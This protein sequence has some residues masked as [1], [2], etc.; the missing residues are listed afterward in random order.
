MNKRI[1]TLAI[2]AIFSVSIVMGVTTAQQ[3]EINIAFSINL[4]SP[5]T[6][7]ARN[8]WSLLMEQ[9]LPKIGIGITFHESTGWGNIAPRTWSYPFL[10]YDYIPTY[11][12]GGYDL[13]FVGWS[14]PLDL[15][16]QALYETTAITPNG[17]NHYQYSNP[18]YDTLL[19][20]Y[21]AELDTTQ[22]L[23]LAKDLQE[24]IYEDLPGIAL[25]YPRSLF[26]FKEGL[27]GIDDL[28]LAST[29]HRAE[30]WDDPDDHIIKYA[31]PADLREPNVYQAESFYD[32]QWMY[33]VYGCPLKRAQ[34]S[35]IW[36]PEIASAIEVST[37][38][39]DKINVTV[40]LDSLAKFSDDSD[41]LPEDL[42]Y[43]YEL[44]MT[45]A[46]GS[47][48]YG[49]LTYWFPT[50]SSIS[51]VGGSGGNV[52]GGQV[53]FEFSGVFNL[54]ESIFNTQIID[55]SEVQ[56][57]ISA[58]G[59]GIFNDVPGTGN[60]QWSLVKSCG[61]F[62]VESYDSINSVVKLVPNPYWHGE[63]VKL[64]EWYLTFI[65]GKDAAVAAL[66][67]DEIDLMDAQYFPVLA[68]FENQAGIEGVLV[69]D[70]SHQEMSI[71]M[72][73]PVMGTGELTPVGTAEAAKYVRKAISH[74]VPRQTI[75]DEILEGLG[76]PATTAVPDSVVGYDDTLEPYAYDL[77]LAIDYM[78]NAGFTVEVPYTSPTGIAGLIF[79][80]FL[81]LA[82]IE[83]MRRLRSK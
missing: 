35:H 1:M 2:I 48:N 21:M 31:I 25:V 32:W 54:W 39:D 72:L 22:R 17:D 57:L 37:V 24:I 7:P 36:E 30:F 19:E 28:L 4:L 53:L 45:P 44:H 18:A 50:N 20:D 68:D 46:V 13:L 43:S 61:P 73:H 3:T 55:K 67:A 47:S 79:I 9:T 8:Q 78:E 38:I 42:K 66:L 10:D 26:G 63:P 60:A 70:P 71:N 12:E 52:A 6:S 58:H 40:T 51:I 56:P 11:S 65:A 81:G 74:A 80:S 76:A 62:M 15:N 33:P 69:K 27:V 16:L 14:W 5:N 83:S 82:A 64:T 75:V 77:N 29:N 41:V 59:Y 34:D 49:T 23:S